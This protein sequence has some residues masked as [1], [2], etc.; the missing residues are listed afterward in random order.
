MYV[1]VCI[2]M[3]MYVYVCICMYM[4][5]YVCICM[6]V[7]II[8]TIKSMY[9]YYI[10]SDLKTFSDDNYIHLPCDFSRDETGSQN[11]RLGLLKDVN[12]HVDGS[13][14]RLL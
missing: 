5:V 12:Q 11:L 1:Y 14:L 13:C 7:Y 4:Y 6:Y 9:A 2:C 8:Y 3:Y 10:F